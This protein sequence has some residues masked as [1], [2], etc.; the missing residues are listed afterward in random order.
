MTMGGKHSAGKGSRYRPVD[1]KKWDRNWERIFG[2]RGAF[3]KVQ[4]D[5]EKEIAPDVMAAYEQ[6]RKE[7]SDGHVT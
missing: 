3:R 5:V 7:D 2:K 1:Q 4:D 6:L